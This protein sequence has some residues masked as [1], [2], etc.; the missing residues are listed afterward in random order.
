MKGCLLL[1][2]NLGILCGKV[3]L[4]GFIQH[5]CKLSLRWWINAS[6]EATNLVELWDEEVPGADIDY[7]IQSDRLV[8]HLR[9]EELIPHGGTVE[10]LAVPP[11]QVD[12]TD[13]H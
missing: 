2:I 4:D 8:A 5:L 1:L 3:F 9:K 12:D 6:N 7:E 13:F 10:S 11:V